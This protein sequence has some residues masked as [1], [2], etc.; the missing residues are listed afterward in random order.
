MVLKPVYGGGLGVGNRGS[1]E[2][3]EWDVSRNDD[4]ANILLGEG[5]AFW[6]TVEESKRMIDPTVGE[7]PTPY[8]PDRLSP[9]DARCHRC[10]WRDPCQGN[11]LMEISKKDNG[12]FVPRNDLLPLYTEYKERKKLLQ[13]AEDLVEEVEEELKT[14]I[15]DA[16]RVT[17]N[18]R[19][20]HYAPQTTMRWDGAELAAYVETLRSVLRKQLPPELMGDE[21]FNRLYPAMQKK[22]S[23][24]RP[25]RVY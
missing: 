24:S 10:E 16:P 21:E 22:P 14:K 7:Y 5:V 1:G 11:A 13:Q 25:F 15:G 3:L 4:I 18:G 19:R 9:D 6:R 17:V 8:A 23:I 12:D 20:V 2:L